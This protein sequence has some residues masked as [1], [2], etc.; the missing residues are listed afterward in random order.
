[1]QLGE[2]SLPVADAAETQAQSGT[3]GVRHFGLTV[4]RVYL[5]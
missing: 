3:V 2:A 5:S 1:M 4:G